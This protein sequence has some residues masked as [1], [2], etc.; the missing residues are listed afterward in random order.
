MGMRVHFRSNIHDLQK[1]AKVHSRNNKKEEKQSI[2]LVV[3]FVVLLH[4]KE[5][6]AVVFVVSSGLLSSSG[7]AGANY[8]VRDR[9]AAGFLAKPC[10]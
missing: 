5:D 6:L 4:V 7:E 8:L 1:F 10:E 2:N 3:V 9:R